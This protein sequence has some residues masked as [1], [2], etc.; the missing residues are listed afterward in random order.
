MA[1]SH[2]MIEPFQYNQVF[3][4]SYVMDTM[5]VVQNEFKLIKK[6]KALQIL[7]LPLLIQRLLMKSFV[8]VKSLFRQIHLHLQERSSIS[9]YPDKF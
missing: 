1:E 7:I 2:G 8:D 5:F 6:E 4:V 3:L 9:E